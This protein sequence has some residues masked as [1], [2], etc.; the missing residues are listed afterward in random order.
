MS[1]I[2]WIRRDLRLQDNPALRSALEAG[3]VVPVFILDPFL[4]ESAAPARKSFLFAALR[5]LDEDLRRR[6]SRL[7]VRSGSPEHA[8]QALVRETGSSTI[9]AEE[10]YTPYARKRD[11]R[12]AASLP[13]VR[14][15]GASFF[16]PAEVVKP[17]GSPYVVF[18]PYAR[19][20]K[21]RLT[22]PA[23]FPAPHHI[24]SPALPASDPIP[25]AHAPSLFPVG[26]TEVYRRLDAFLHERIFAYQGQRDRMDLAGTSALSPYLRFG[27]IS[28]RSLVTAACRAAE[29][30]GDAASL[31]SAQA[32]LNELI[33]REFYQQVLYHFPHVSRASFRPSLSA[34]PWRDDPQSFEA[35]KAGM[36][37]VPVVDAAMR[38][39]AQTGWMHNRARMISASYLV[40]DLLIDWQW[41]ER[42]FMQNLVDG[43]PSSNNGGWQWV[44][45]TGTD[46]APYFRI[47][48]PVLQ[49]RKFDP[50]GDYVRRWVPE[51]A[52][53]SAQDI[54]APWEQDIRV[55]GYPARPLVDHAA[56]VKRARQAYQ[57]S[58]LIHAGQP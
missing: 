3:P 39:L 12:V 21:E 11:T 35:W 38:Q 2:W 32:W 20:W 46:A 54:H 17:D 6:G 8:L 45:G 41:G 18:T 5:A 15:L 42:W 40:K 14:V 29:S 28:M 47:F 37:G 9:F 23:V 56:A 43:D 58:R 4:L 51:L 50:Q 52:A 25:P 44:A 48:N 30:A 55:P 19:A 53:L 24:F 26:E 33:W 7:V 27:L 34:V 57:Y 10:D 1:S 16:H 13:L 31:R 49:G 36:T 22:S